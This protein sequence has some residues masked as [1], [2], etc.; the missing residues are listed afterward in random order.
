[1]PV[2]ETNILTV[3]SFRDLQDSPV[4]RAVGFVTTSS[5]LHQ[6]P[7]DHCHEDFSRID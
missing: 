1:M 4:S 7:I 2:T 5:E 6:L 3:Q